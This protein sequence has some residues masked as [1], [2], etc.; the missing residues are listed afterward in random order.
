[1]RGDPGRKTT[2]GECRLFLLKLSFRAWRR[3]PLA[4]FFNVAV[5]AFLATA[6]AGA[7]WVSL[8]M[9]PAVRQFA[10]QMTAYGYFDPLATPDKRV[11]AYQ[12][13]RDTI[14]VS[15]GS[16]AVLVEQE[17]FLNRLGVRFPA[18]AA[19]VRDLPPAE[20]DHVV[21]SYVELTGVLAASELERLAKTNGI[22]SVQTTQARNQAAAEAFR[23]VNRALGFFAVGI[24]IVFATCAVQVL[25][26]SARQLTDAVSLLRS[27]GSGYWKLRIPGLI[28]GLT[29]GFTSGILAGL[30]FYFG[31]RG[32]AVPVMQILPATFEA[33]LP[34]TVREAS[35]LGLVVACLCV[36]VS[37]LVSRESRGLGART[38]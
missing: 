11:N 21:P 29:L 8:Q 14:A 33:L 28:Q 35:E 31:I 26:V 6:G 1:M 37:F 22:L 24:W 13:I 25:R 19:E 36:G 9:K 32:V 10:G 20:R 12:E 7:Q 23:A 30:G 4:Q 17:E 15:T 18:L 34:P 2:D 5:V 27:W 38:P 16:K 3:E